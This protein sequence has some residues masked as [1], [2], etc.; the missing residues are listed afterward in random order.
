MSRV[1][2]FSVILMLVISTAGFSNVAINGKHKSLVKDGKKVDCTYC[3]TGQ[4]IEKKK[5]QMANKKFNG[6][7]LSQMKA[8]AGKDCHK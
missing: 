2:A 1:T 3:H 8:C 7:G 5:G 4:K 6:K